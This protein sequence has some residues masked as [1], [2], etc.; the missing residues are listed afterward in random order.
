[1]AEEDGNDQATTSVEIDE[2]AIGDAAPD[3]EQISDD[4]LT[5]TILLEGEGKTSSKEHFENLAETLPETE[6][7]KLAEKYLDLIDQ[8]MQDRKKRDD[9]QAAGLEKSGV[10]GP[11]PGGAGFEGASKVTHPVLIESYIDFAAQSIKELMPPNGPVRMK[12]EGKPNKEKMDRAKRKSAFMN[13]QLTRQIQSYRPELERLLTQ[14]P[15]GGSQ[16]MKGYQNMSRGCPDF[17][18]I[19]IDD[20]VLPFH[21][22]NFFDLSRKFHRMKLSD[23]TYER[24]IASGQYRDL[25]LPRSYGADFDKSKSA[26]VRD[27]IEGKDNSGSS[28][29]TE[30]RIAFEGCVYLDNIGDP[31]APS[32]DAV[33]YI[34][35]IDEESRRVLALYRNWD[36]SDDKYREIDYIVDFTFIPWDGIFGLSLLQCM[37]GL[38]DAM[39][40]SLRA[41]LDSALIN[42][43]PGAFKLKGN[44]SGASLS[45]SPTQVTEVD[46]LGQ[47]DIRKIYMPIP[48][49]PPSPMLF[50]L[51]GFLT[52]AAQEVVGTAEEKIADAGNNMPVG[53]ALALIEQGAKVFSAIHAR[54]HD[55]QRRILEILHRLNRDHLPDGKVKFGSDDEDYVTR[56]DFEGSMDVRPVSDP[57][58]FS[59]A[60]RFAQIQ[61][62]VQTLIGLGQVPALAGA[63]QKVDMRALLARA[64]EQ[65]KIP[66]YEEFLPEDP[67][68]EPLNPVDENILMVMGKPVK[69]YAGQNHEAHIQVLLDFSKN[70]L[71]GQSPIIAGKFVTA[72]LNHLQ[73]HILVWYEEMMKRDAATAMG[74][75][76]DD[77]E[78]DDDPESS[79]ALAKSTAV[80]DQAAQLAFGKIPPL[81]QAA[82]QLLQQNA[83]KPPQDPMVG[84]A[85]QEVQGKQQIAQGQLSL[86]Q[87]QV[88][89]DAQAKLTLAQQKAAEFQGK[90]QAAQQEYDL[91]MQELGINAQTQ[92]RTAELQSQTD[93]AKTVH[94]NASA[95]HIAAMKLTAD[96][97]TKLSDGA[98]LSE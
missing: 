28:Q 12:I 94:D 49:N 48:F 9:M 43:M 70:P 33:P 37:G 78:W 98:S 4:G 69:A 32:D 57:N 6:L 83:P 45:T 17:E 41:L 73:D 53:T 35:T 31:V 72:G 84:V 50:Q 36:E 71:F 54:M 40:G 22:R 61:F 3:D 38:P 96:A 80:V 75:Q 13:W 44:P 39:T 29:E 65:A 87:Q 46:A 55:S 5:T 47:D 90:M 19:P 64:F 20:M 74:K 27:K 81:I 56:E 18:F 66:D 67:K 25:E 2:K 86:K 7:D 79:V 77:V 93:I 58:I 10:S 30:E 1:M 82:M 34:I 11:A 15:V 63:V 85:M 62:V 14:L 51:L 59:E 52:S 21:A 26:Q 16:Y 91:K 68:A 8:D 24:R 97:H 76:L 95:Q 60:Q 89:A 42:N 88:Q 92:I 23:F